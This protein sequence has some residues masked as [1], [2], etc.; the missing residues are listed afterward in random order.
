MAPEV[1]N[2]SYYSSKADI[3]SVG[4]ILYALLNGE[5]PFEAENIADFEKKYRTGSYLMQES[6]IMKLTLET[7]LFLS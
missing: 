2:K 1:Y 5:T 7:I 4:A 6:S 3:W